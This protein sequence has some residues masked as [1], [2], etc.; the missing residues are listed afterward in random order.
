MNDPVPMVSEG[1]SLQR[2]R[3]YLASA[4]T[5]LSTEDRELIFDASDVVAEVCTAR[6]IDLYEPRKI[7]DPVHHP[8]I[9][10]AEVYRMDRQKVL[11][12]D[13]LFYLAHKPSTGAGQE[14][15]FAQDAMIPVVVMAPENSAISR[16]V[17]GMPGQPIILRFK[18]L[19]DLKQALDMELVKLMPGIRSREQAVKGYRSNTVGSRIR[20]LREE[21]GLTPEDVERAARVPGY[22]S[23][24]QIENWESGTDADN[25]MSLLC[26]RELAVALGV[27]VADLVN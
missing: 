17:T 19:S 11:R 23:A 6:G 9:A 13:L 15:I 27:R 7:T 24:L 26:L 5:G 14:L 16:M 18:K 2:V 25:N 8:H 10:D 22:I 4:L 12:S 21:K 20:Q 1:P 3:A